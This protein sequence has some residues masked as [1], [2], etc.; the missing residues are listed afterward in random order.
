L[1]GKPYYAKVQ[2]EDECRGLRV[3]AKRGV[4]VNIETI[5]GIV[6][7]IIAIIMLWFT[8]VGI[9]FVWIIKQAQ[10]VTDKDKKTNAR[11]S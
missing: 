7:V 9:A 10:A 5:L 8:S 1:W 6:L 3:R 11:K 4:I 2:I